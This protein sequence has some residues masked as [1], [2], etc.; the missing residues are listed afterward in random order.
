[1]NY[2][3]VIPLLLTAFFEQTVT[4]LTRITVSYRAVEL[5][6]SVVWLGIITAFFAILPMLFAV[7][8]GRFIDRGNDART[9]WLG[10]GLMSLTCLGFVIW[11][12]LVPL[13][14]LTALLGISHLMLVISQQVLCARDRT[15]AVV[16][17]MIG[18][19]MVANAIGQGIGPYIVGW[20][21]GSAS[22]PPTHF[23]FTVGF[24]FSLLILIFSLMLRPSPPRPPKP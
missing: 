1:M 24:S 3:F 13:L 5:E 17:R 4:Q 19:Y 15:P 12:S 7:K 18:N 22:I 23:L 2:R 10:A 8:I 6:L 20:A 16:D 11:Q 14:I 21:G 9:A